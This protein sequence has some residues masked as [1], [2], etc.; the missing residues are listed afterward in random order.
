MSILSRVSPLPADLQLPS[1]FLYEAHIRV[2]TE[3]GALVTVHYVLSFIHLDVGAK[4]LT[5]GAKFLNGI[6]LDHPVLLV[7]DY[8]YQL[9]TDLNFPIGMYAHVVGHMTSSA[10]GC[11][12]REGVKMVETKIVLKNH[13]SAYA[14][15][16]DLSIAIPVQVVQLCVFTFI[17]WG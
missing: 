3:H 15:P 17:D 13:M 9:S 4:Y 11:T 6:N 8:A 16:L 5:F 14:E 7:S 2:A 10:L 1:N 12:V